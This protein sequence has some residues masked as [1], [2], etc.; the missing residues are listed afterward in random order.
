[1]QKRTTL[2]VTGED[3]TLEVDLTDNQIKDLY[4]RAGFFGLNWSL[5]DIIQ[6]ADDLGYNITEA[7]AMDIANGLERT[8]DP[9]YGITWA[10]LEN[11]IELYIEDKAKEN[12]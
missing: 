3:F 1:M 6:R 12:V 5:G 2:K 9:E 4:R 11:A 8:G 7:E 10:H